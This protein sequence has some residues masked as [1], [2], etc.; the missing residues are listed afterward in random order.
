MIP[1]MPTAHISAA[2]DDIAETVLLPGDPLRA[3]W[4]AETYLESP[5]LVTQVRNMFGYTGTVRGEPVSVM[6]TGMG[7][8]SVSIYATELARFYGVRRML[9]VGSCGG[10]GAEVALGDVIVVTGASTDSA[11]N[12]TRFGGADLAAVSDHF[13]TASLVAAA[14]S[15]HAASSGS[16]VRVGRVLT[17]DLFYEP[18]GPKFELAAKLGHLAVEMEV[19]GLLGVAAE[20]GIAA[21][22]LLTVSDHLDRHESM[23]P[24]ERERGFASMIELALGGLFPPND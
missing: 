23:T 3:K 16:T 1:V 20:E 8:P 24:E 21:G 4:I 6:G 2:P 10:L 9:R 11:V 15:A 22:A 5:R 17:S 18:E 7:I 19:A 12:R 13:L 14:T